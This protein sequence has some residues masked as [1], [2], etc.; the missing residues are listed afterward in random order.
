MSWYALHKPR[1]P[2]PVLAAHDWRVDAERCSARSRLL[3]RGQRRR[4]GQGAGCGGRGRL[5]LRN[6]RAVGAVPAAPERGGGSGGAD[7]EG[8]QATGAGRR[9]AG[10]LHGPAQR[11]LDCRRH[12]LER[13]LV[14]GEGGGADVIAGA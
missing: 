10:S 3:F 7:H 9:G 11:A 13:S 6:R 5:G 2:A 4:H 14:A 1:L 12:G 8:R